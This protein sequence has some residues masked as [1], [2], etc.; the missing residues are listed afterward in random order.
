MM[1]NASSIL[2]MSSILQ[3]V[4]SGS[5]GVVV[6]EGEGSGTPSTSGSSGF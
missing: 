5:S 3:S 1:K 6:G 2:N 4:G